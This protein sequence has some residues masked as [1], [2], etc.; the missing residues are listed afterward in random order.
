MAGI[1]LEMNTV[2]QIGLMYKQGV[3]IK[4][5]ARNLSLSKNTV[6]KYLR[7]LDLIKLTQ[8]D[9]NCKTESGSI[10]NDDV[11]NEQKSRLEILQADFPD[12]EDLLKQTGMTLH[13]LWQRYKASHNEGYE[14]SQFCYHYQKYNLTRH[15]VMHFEHEYGD[16]LYLDFAGKTV[17][18]V[19]RGT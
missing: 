11:P 8:E 2:Q 4:T 18:Y 17:S 1:T 12:Y 6:K 3:K 19:E 13:L 9:D 16:R 15:A 14:Y 7:E 10:S 5:I